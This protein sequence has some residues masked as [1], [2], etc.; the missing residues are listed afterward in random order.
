[1]EKTSNSLKNTSNTD[2]LK[3][4]RSEVENFLNNI[5][6]RNVKRN[7]SY[8]KIYALDVRNMQLNTIKSAYI[9]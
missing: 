6:M 7:I 1:M 9:F 8:I 2:G 3:T 4:S 5:S